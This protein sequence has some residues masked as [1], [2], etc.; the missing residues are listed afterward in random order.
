MFSTHCLKNEHVICVMS[1]DLGQVK[2]VFVFKN[3]QQACSKLEE[4]IRSLEEAK[5][6]GE[7]HQ[8]KLQEAHQQMDSLKVI[9]YMIW[10]LIF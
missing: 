6:S 9:Q 5:K 8:R 7:Q 2:Y 1:R 4:K 3:F 10:S